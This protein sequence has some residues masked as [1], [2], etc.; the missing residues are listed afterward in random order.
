MYQVGIEGSSPIIAKFYRPERWTRDQILEEHSFTQALKEL[1][2]SV[3]APLIDDAG[4]TLLHHQGFDL[5][6]IHI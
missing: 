6:L 2:I 4:N 5:S 3:V 1:E